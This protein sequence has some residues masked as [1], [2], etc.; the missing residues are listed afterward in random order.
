MSGPPQSG[1]VDGFEHPCRKAQVD[2]IKRGCG[3]TGFGHGA[4]LAPVV[5]LVQFFV[6]SL[7]CSPPGGLGSGAEDEVPMAETSLLHLAPIEQSL[8]V[9]NLAVLTDDEADEEGLLAGNQHYQDLQ[10]CD[11]ADLEFAIQLERKLIDRL[12]GS[13]DSAREESAIAEERPADDERA[14]LWHLD[15]GVASAVV[16]MVVLGAHTVLSCNGGEYGRAH[17]FATP[18]IRAYIAAASADQLVVLSRRAGVGVRQEDGLVVLYAPS[19]RAFLMFAEQTL[20]DL[21]A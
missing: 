3:A 8:D 1:M 17:T 2:A 5:S 12:V 4:T 15:V 20:E 18:Q 9:E 11:V 7:W 19:C 13:A 14:A 16:A 10:D 6:C 21:T